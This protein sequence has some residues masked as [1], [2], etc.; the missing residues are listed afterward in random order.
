M[1]TNSNQSL[2]VGLA[3]FIAGLFVAFVAWNGYGMM[4]GY[5]GG[6]MGSR[7]AAPVTQTIG[8][9]DAMHGMTI[10][11]S[12]KTGASFDRAFLD[13]MIVHHEGAV[14]MAQQALLNAEHQ[15]L[16]DMARDIITAQTKEIEQ[17]K[18]WRAAWF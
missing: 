16:K 12:G 4:S 9:Q 13:E 10:G 7:T 14:L 1:Q 11:L 5:L 2:V 18:T 3:A 6:M 15:E 8:M 17:M